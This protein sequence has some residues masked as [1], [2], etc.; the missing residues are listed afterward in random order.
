MSQG[1]PPKVLV[2][3]HSGLLGG[4]G[5][6]MVD[7]CRGLAPGF[8]VK[9][10]LPSR[11]DQL[12]RH[13]AEHGLD[14][15][16]FGFRMAKIP[17]Y[18]GGEPVWHPRTWFYVVGILRQRRHWKDV[19]EAED[20]DVVIAN[21][22]V[23]AWLSLCT[24]R[25]TTVLMVRETLRGR[26]SSLINRSLRSLRDRFDLVFYLSEHDRTADR[27]SR[28]Q[29]V[30]V[31]DSADARHFEV[32]VDR[33]DAREQL[34][35]DPDRPTTLFLGGSNRLKGLDTLI[36][37]ARVSS[38]PG[39]QVVVAG[40][41]PS[42]DGP[43]LSFLTG[44]RRFDRRVLRAVAALPASVSV[45]FVGVRD[46]VDLLFAACDHV[47]FPMNQPHQA[48]PAFEAGFH[49]R[50]VVITDFANIADCVRD[51]EN[52]LLFPVGDSRALARCIDRL[53]ANHALSSRLGEAN[54]EHA[55]AVHE[56][57]RIFAQVRALLE[58]AVEDARQRLRT[59]REAS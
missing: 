10:Y 36:A 17:Y 31:R 27:L 41:P 7:L 20:P 35:L 30:V 57:E 29:A 44:R 9:A 33:R 4:A 42:D 16:T 37:A 38:T 52:G 8:H 49:G 23:L 24:G 28:A 56:Q 13:V 58:M 46:D 43:R 51:G 48:R 21:S 19:I 34:A 11:P 50:A 45:E 54:R 15:A 53:H 22:S 25:R 39:L 12:A 55:T 2:V 6:S 3:H 32:T 1:D 47:V 14:V 26:P 40:R 5:K 59:Q 18:S